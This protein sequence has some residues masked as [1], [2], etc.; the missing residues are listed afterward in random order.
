M[1]NKNRL[2]LFSLLLFMNL[3]VV[4][5]DKQLN[6]NQVAQ[7]SKIEYNQPDTTYEQ[8]KALNT[9][10][11]GPDEPAKRYQNPNT[12]KRLKAA[13]LQIDSLNRAQQP[14]PANVNSG[15]ER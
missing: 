5:C 6:D 12:Q 15:T 14:N 13:R 7:D 1:K 11:N 4:S 2:T 9:Q 8:L 3:F 10:L